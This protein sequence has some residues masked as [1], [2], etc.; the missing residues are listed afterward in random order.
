MRVWKET[1]CDVVLAMRNVE[2]TRDAWGKKKRLAMR[3]PSAQPN[4]TEAI[5]LK[6]DNPPHSIHQRDNLERAKGGL[7]R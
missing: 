3:W 6:R 5:H 1:N 7:H 2:K 4:H